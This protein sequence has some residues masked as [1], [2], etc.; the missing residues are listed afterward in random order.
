[1]FCFHTRDKIEGLGL[2]KQRERERRGSHHAFLMAPR[3]SLSAL[4][5]KRTPQINGKKI[6]GCSQEYFSQQSKPKMKK[7]MLF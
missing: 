3:A 6:K 4:V 2:G 7:I 5:L 1:M